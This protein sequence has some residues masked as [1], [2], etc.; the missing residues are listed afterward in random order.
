LATS[1][2]RDGN[3]TDAFDTAHRQ[4]QSTR[5]HWRT[6]LAAR[7]R[8]DTQVLDASLRFELGGL[9]LEPCPYRCGAGELRALALASVQLPVH[10]VLEPLGDFKAF[11]DGGGDDVCRST[12]PESQIVYIDPPAKQIV[13]P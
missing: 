12:R 13:D 11:G 1:I 6:H 3:P 5:R 8:N 10:R 2:E 7:D 4:R 9:T